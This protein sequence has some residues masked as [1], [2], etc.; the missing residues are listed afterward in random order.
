MLMRKKKGATGTQRP[1]G[2]PS[3]NTYLPMYL[4]LAGCSTRVLN[5]NPTSLWSIMRMGAQTF[6]P[7]GTH[8]NFAA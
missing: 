4:L 7:H 3:D 5:A 6:V 8:I 1:D 2:C